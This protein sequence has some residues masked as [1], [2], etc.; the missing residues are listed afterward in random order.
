MG[1][2]DPDRPRGRCGSSCTASTVHRHLR[3]KSPH[4]LIVIVDCV[5]QLGVSRPKEIR[6]LVCG[7]VDIYDRISFGLSTFFGQPVDA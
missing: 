7:S 5:T 1:F 3:Y 6:S 4:I 2:G